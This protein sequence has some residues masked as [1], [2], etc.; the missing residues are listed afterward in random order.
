M[1]IH[2]LFFKYFY[3]TCVPLHIASRTMRSLAAVFLYLLW[4]DQIF[5]AHLLGTIALGIRP[6]SHQ[7]ILGDISC[8]D[9]GG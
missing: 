7:T 8:K 3:P 5:S 2:S 4:H 1:S 6:F 9:L